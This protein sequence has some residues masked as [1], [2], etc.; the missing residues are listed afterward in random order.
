MEQGFYINY[1]FKCYATDYP[2]LRDL[3]SNEDYKFE[4][5]CFI[6]I[7]FQRSMVRKSYS[8]LNVILRNAKIKSIIKLI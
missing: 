2:V 3:V 8:V 5:L 6:F 4:N 7:N 1:Q